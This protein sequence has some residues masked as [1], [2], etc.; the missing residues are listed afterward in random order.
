M[1]GTLPEYER[2]GF[3]TAV[4]QF[5]MQRAFELGCEKVTLEATQSGEKIYSK[6]GFNDE[7][8]IELF[9]LSQ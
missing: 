1:V 2:K 4:T 7:G 3:G 9:N 6:I 8:R 5:A